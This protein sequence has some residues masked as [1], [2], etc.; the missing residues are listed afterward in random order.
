VTYNML[1]SSAA[2][3]L[4]RGYPGQEYDRLFDHTQAAGL[5]VVAIRVLAGGALSGS[6]DRHPIASPPP[7]PIG[8]ARTYE[9]DLKLAQKLRPLVDEGFA[10][11][12][13]E[14]A[15]RFSLA[16][17]SVATILVGMATV[18]EFDRALAAVRKGPLRPDALARLG[19]LQ[20]SFVALTA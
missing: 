20:Q 17:S 13:A 15:I 10:S 18:D 16:N 2:E 9:E 1:N 12:L 19:E 6:E 11:S 5:G 4:P 14:A 8:S 7:A 3:R